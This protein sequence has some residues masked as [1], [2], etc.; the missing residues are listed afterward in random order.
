MYCGKLTKIK[1]DTFKEVI[2]IIQNTHL[3][4]SPNFLIMP[5][6]LDVTICD[7]PKQYYYFF[8]PYLWLND[9]ICL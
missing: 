8:L 7:D 5:E 3:Y 2:L 1:K 6:K 4:S 9:N